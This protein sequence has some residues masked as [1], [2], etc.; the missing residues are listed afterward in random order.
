[1]SG[2]FSIRLKKD[3]VTPDLRRKIGALK[4]LQPVYS[5]IGLGLVSYT[6]RSFRDASLRTVTWQPKS[7]GATSNLISKGMLMSSIRV[8]GATRRGVTIGTDRRYAAI[9][10]LG[11]VIRAKGGKPLVFQIG[12]RTIFAKK[13]TIPARPFLPFTQD[14]NL[15]KKAVAPVGRIVK[16]ATDRALGVK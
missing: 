7:T 13:V 3:T 12:A 2:G 14:G 6:K 15:S 9:H 4:N 10:Q 16:A 1:V 11:G 5:A 8:T